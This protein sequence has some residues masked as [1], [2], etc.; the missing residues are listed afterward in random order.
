MGARAMIL[1]RLKAH[2]E[3]ENWF[4]VAIDFAIVVFGV[5]IGL[6][7]ANWNET[8][9]QQHKQQV[10]LQRLEADF[11]AI[12]QRLDEHFEVYAEMIAGADYLLTLLRLDEE[13]F[14]VAEI[15]RN[16]LT[17]ALNALSG[18]RVP[19]PSS[20][21]YLEMRSEGQLSAMKNGALRDALASYDLVLDIMRDVSRMS[22]DTH[23]QQFHH[24][25]QYY[26][27]RTVFDDTALSGIRQEVLNYDLGEMRRD[28]NVETAI[29]LL[30]TNALNSLSQ[31]R[32]QRQRI[33]NILALIETET[34]E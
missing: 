23:I 15:N 4:A 12:D 27:A 5:F 3:K 17:K 31:R 32:L 25:Q 30:Q 19:P 24:V 13:S 14:R 2:I 34:T 21:T 22:V 8:R 33:E 20:A 11:V 16:Q 10:Y 6:Q 29:K 28:P 9:G 7:V 1:R 26:T 18:Q